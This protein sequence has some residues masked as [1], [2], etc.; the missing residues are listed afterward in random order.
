MKF[1]EKM[2]ANRWLWLNKRTLIFS[3]FTRPFSSHCGALFDRCS[4][5][6]TY[7]LESGSHAKSLE[8]RPLS[9]FFTLFDVGP[10][11]GPRKDHVG[12]RRSGNICDFAV[13]HARPT[14]QSP[15]SPWT[16][17]RP[18]CVVHFWRGP[19]R[20]LGDR[21]SRG[22]VLAKT[23]RAPFFTRKKWTFPFSS[24]VLHVPGQMRAKVLRPWPHPHAGVYLIL[25]MVYQM[26]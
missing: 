3:L 15:F 19:R 22:E 23:S 12:G 10:G 21:G 13:V 4:D 7:P 2:S 25:I 1:A 20:D 18:L 26:P 11:Q 24:R 16:S 9:F 5:L 17:R 14:L 8:S 6:E